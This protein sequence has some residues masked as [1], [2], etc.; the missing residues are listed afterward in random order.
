MYT[1]IIVILR[2]IARYWYPGLPYETLSS[3]ISYWT[4]LIQKWYKENG[5][6][7]TIKRIKAIRLTTTRY[8]CGQPLLVNHDRLAVTKDG[9][10]ICLIPF[11][12]LVDSKLPQALRFTLTCL[13]VSR[14]FTFPGVI[15]F[16][17]ITSKSTATI[18]KIDDNF[19]KIFV[20][21]FCKNY[22]PLSNRPSPFISFLSMKAGPIIGPAILSAHI[23]AARFT[24]QNLWGLAHIGGDKFMEWVKE[25]KSSI[26]INEINLLS[27][28]SKGWKA[29]DPRIG[30]RKFLRIDD[31][32]SK[33]R[34]VGCY[35]Y[36]SQLALT[37][38]SEWAFNSLKINFPKDRTFTQ[39]PV[40]TDKMDSECYH[41]LD[42]S[43]ATDRF[44][45]SLQVQ[46]LSE[47]AGP[48]FAGAWKNLMVAEPFLAQYWVGK[49]SP[50]LIKK[51]INYEVGQPMG[52]RSSWATFTLCH[53]MIVQ[54]AAY[55]ENLYPTNEYILLGDDVVIY[56]NKIALQYTSLIRS[57]GVEISESKSHVS[58][59]TYEFA[60]RWFQKGIEISPVPIAGF[61]SNVLNPKLLYSQL[62]ELI[63]K[64]RGPRSMVCSIQVMTNL[65]ERLTIPSP[66]HFFDSIPNNGLFKQKRAYSSSQVKLFIRC[67]E[68]LQL[69][70]RNT[71]EFDENR[72]RSFMA[73]ATRSNE[74]TIPS[75]SV[76]LNQEWIRAGSGVV[77]GMAMSV[78]KN[79]ST[80]FT[81]FKN[82]YIPAVS[83]GFQD[84][85]T[86]IAVHPL[87]IAIYGS[88]KRFHEMNKAMGYTTD[89]NKQLETITLLDLDKLASQNRKSEE[90]IFTFST[91]GRKLFN[92]LRDDPDLI[93]AK[94]QTMRFGRSLM[95]IQL[96]MAKE[97]PN[98]KKG[99]T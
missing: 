18:G 56:N 91:F 37:P 25:L 21:D 53:H 16:D 80:Y 74:Y 32:E 42:L 71:K 84:G 35:D 9:F 45:I 15:N 95:D 50:K 14:A 24:G 64:G 38:Y 52:A 92:Q 12:E 28:F 4:S 36:I 54:Y 63:Y 88:V 41:S 69:V 55:K 82:N 33:V 72:T 67:F 87:T 19:V 27:S 78:S 11:K 7:S 49:R 99:L 81:K 34:I 2:W 6:I 44:P 17:S 97:F 47:V 31:P 65:V 77:N 76:S 98:I 68:E 86:P 29:T 26:K 66:S 48:G 62:L 57:L 10:P 13:G 5:A 8:I 75:N 43:A 23:S 59:D 89:L 96:A 70:F 85:L 1:N 20:K 93:I 39:D 51:L 79:L 46:F 22:D 73:K 90:L 30:N 61:S 94:A 40:I 3:L 83:H 58:K 60:K